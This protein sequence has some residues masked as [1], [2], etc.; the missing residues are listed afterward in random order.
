[1]VPKQQKIAGSHTTPPP[2]FSPLTLGYA[3]RLLAPDFFSALKN[4]ATT[5]IP[6]HSSKNRK[7]STFQKNQLK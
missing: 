4:K 7:E 2:H 3:A 6:S 1:M 5:K